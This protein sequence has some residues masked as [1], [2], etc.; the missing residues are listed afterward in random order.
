MEVV[1]FVRLDITRGSQ[2]ACGSVTGVQCSTTFIASLF[3][4][5]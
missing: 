3:V 2:T 1:A 4:L 5:K